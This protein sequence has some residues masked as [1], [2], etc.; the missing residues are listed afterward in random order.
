MTIVQLTGDF[1]MKICP[2]CSGELKQVVIYNQPTYSGE[3]TE[4]LTI[5]DLECEDC[6]TRFSIPDETEE[7]IF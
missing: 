4:M 6:K 7:V 2:E 3:F 1:K 5:T